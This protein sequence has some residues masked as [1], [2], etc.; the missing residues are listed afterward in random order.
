M[1]LKKDCLPGPVKSL[2]HSGHLN[3]V[4]PEFRWK[5]W[6]CRRKTH[7]SENDS[8]HLSHINRLCVGFSLPDTSDVRL[9]RFGSLTGFKESCLLVPDAAFLDSFSI[10]GLT[11]IC[12]AKPASR[13]VLLIVLASTRGRYSTIDLSPSV[14]ECFLLSLEYSWVSSSSFSL[15]MDTK[16][17]S[18][19]TFTIGSIKRAASNFCLDSTKSFRKLWK[20]TNL[21]AHPLHIVCGK[22]SS[23]SSWNAVVVR[24]V[25]NA[26]KCKGTY[27][28]TG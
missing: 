7:R 27:R 21:S 20:S 16:A 18:C 2:G 8:S 23:K 6:K 3:L 22:P 10:D 19:S 13:F 4:D 1:T 26:R 12:N 15:L 25:Q 24:S 5:C 11:S 17:M 14:I 28:W 9:C